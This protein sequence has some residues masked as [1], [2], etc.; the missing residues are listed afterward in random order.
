M[1]VLYVRTIRT[2]VVLVVP[3]D[4]MDLI[5]TMCM[6]LEYKHNMEAI[7]Q[8]VLGC[9]YAVGVGCILPMRATIA[10]FSI[11]FLCKSSIQFRPHYETNTVL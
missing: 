10:P 9:M 4:N 3:F 8:R 1:Y 6:N 11:N 7:V 5:V 2:I